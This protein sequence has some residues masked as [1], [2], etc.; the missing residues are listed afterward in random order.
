METWT[1]R[2]ATIGPRDA[3]RALDAALDGGAGVA[4]SI[5]VTRRGAADLRAQPDRCERI[6]LSSRPAT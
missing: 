2:R 3:G 4:L 1:G 6:R 5:V